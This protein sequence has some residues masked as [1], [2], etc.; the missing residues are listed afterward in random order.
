MELRD[1]G[2]PRRPGARPG[3]GRG[4]RAD[5]PDVDLRCRSEVGVHKGTTT[6]APP[7]RPAPRSRSASPRSRAPR[8][9]LPSRRGMGADHDGL[10]P[11]FARRPRRG[12]QRRSTAAPTGSSKRVRAP[13]ASTFDFVAST[14]STRSRGAPAERPGW[15]GWRRRPIRC[16]SI[17]DI[18][19]VAELARA[20]AAPLRGRQHVRHAL[21]PATARPR[22]RSRRALDDEVPGRP[23]ATWSAAFVATGDPLLAER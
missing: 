3:H 1:A 10:P 17:V 21:P 20:A 14:T 16:S 2:D 13:R 4:D 5:L 19:A 12:R 23:L 18:R 11:P 7:T 6:R 8:T 15:S 22:R 9:G